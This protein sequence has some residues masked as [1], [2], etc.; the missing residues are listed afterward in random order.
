MQ[1]VASSFINSPR[2]AVYT[3]YHVSLVPSKCVLQVSI[4]ECCHCLV[5]QTLGSQASF[6]LAFMQ[7][8][9]FWLHVST[10]CLPDIYAEVATIFS[11]KPAIPLL[12]FQTGS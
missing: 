4:S 8:L 3:L 6:S 1:E 11:V 9:P 5:Q 7:K 12:Y 2:K 10:Y